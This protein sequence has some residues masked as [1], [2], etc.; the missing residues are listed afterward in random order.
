[1]SPAVALTLPGVQVPARP[2]LCPC[3]KKADLGFSVEG[4]KP[5]KCFVVALSP[6]PNPR[7]CYKV[8]RFLKLR[9]HWNQFGVSHVSSFLGNFASYLLN[10]LGKSLVCASAGWAELWST[11]QPPEDPPHPSSSSLE[12]AATPWDAPAWGAASSPPLLSQ[13]S[14]AKGGSD[15][16]YP[17]MDP[18][19]HSTSHCPCSCSGLGNVSTWSP[20]YAEGVTNSVDFSGN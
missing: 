4:P 15:V 13:R 19:A 7:Q 3:P 12:A 10:I 5:H 11:M 14:A 20:F 1:M 17:G 8:H 2:S 6:F 9:H 18:S 16:G